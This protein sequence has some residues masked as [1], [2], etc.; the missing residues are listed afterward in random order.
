MIIANPIYDTIFKY[1]MKDL[2]IARRFISVILGVEI[3]SIKFSDRERNK[4][5]REKNEVADAIRLFHLDFVAE[6][7]TEDGIKTVLIELQ[8][9]FDMVDIH[10]FRNYLGEEYSRMYDEYIQYKKEL[11][12]SRKNNTNLPDKPPHSL[13]IIPIYIL[14]FELSGKRMITYAD[15][16]L[17]DPNKNHEII[18]EKDNFIDSL[19]HKAYFI[20]VPSIP[21]KT[22]TELE[23]VLSIFNQHFLLKENRWKLDYKEIL[24]DIKNELL[25]D[26]LV[27]LNALVEDEVVR[28]EI[29]AAEEG[30]RYI[31][32]IEVD[33]LEKIIP[34][35]R[36]RDMANQKNENAI[37]IISK[38]FNISIEEATKMI[39]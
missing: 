10:R 32:E 16:V 7:A 34:I 37:K 14:D 17:K 35:E 25:Y 26:M 27:K 38:K 3:K 18:N 19:T 36:E 23:E 15:I 8:K 13:P 21:D 5:L 12:E 9:S 28:K 30:L 39:E 4:L 33:F 11:K 31:D 2:S 6:I 1:L 24:K 22:E 29:E 20:Q